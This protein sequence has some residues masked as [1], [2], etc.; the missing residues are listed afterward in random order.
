MLTNIETELNNSFD[1]LSICDEVRVNAKD[2]LEKLKEKSPLSY[3]HSVSCALISIPAADCFRINR[4]K[5]FFSALLHDVG[6]LEIPSDVLDKN[7]GFDS[8]DM[9]VMRGHPI[10]TFNILYPKFR[11]SAGVGFYH[12]ENQDEGYPESKLPLNGYSDATYNEMHYCARILS[13]IDAYEAM[14]TRENDR[15]GHS[16]LP[17]KTKKE[18]LKLRHGQK[19]MIMKL[20]DK[21]VIG[22]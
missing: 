2:L 5:L 7:Q 13:V 21:E 12:H 14:I 6:K 19:D 17:S 15:Y 9:Q 10:H 20:Y 1:S 22:K 18:L 8:S 11:F 16:I 3:Y 4:N